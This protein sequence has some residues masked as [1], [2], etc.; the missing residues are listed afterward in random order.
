MCSHKYV[1]LTAPSVTMFIN[2]PIGT[3]VF[4]SSLLGC[5]QV[6]PSGFVH[7]GVPH[8]SGL[9]L[10]VQHVQICMNDAQPCTMGQYHGFA[11]SGH[12]I[13]DYT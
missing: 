2:Y 9:F 8:M 3:Q 4:S 6:F 1:T 12:P 5:H 11:A 7:P 10:P 13:P